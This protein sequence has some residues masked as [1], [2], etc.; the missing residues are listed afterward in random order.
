MNRKNACDLFADRYKL[1][2]FIEYDFNIK[3]LTEY[4]EKTKDFLFKYDVISRP[5]YSDPSGKTSGILTDL[6]TVNLSWANKIL[7]YVDTA[8]DYMN[9]HYGYMIENLLYNL[10]LKGQGEIKFI[11]ME[12]IINSCSS[13][14][15]NNLIVLLCD[16]IESNIIAAF[17]FNQSNEVKEYFINDQKHILGSQQWH[18]SR[19]SRENL[20]IITDNKEYIIEQDIKYNNCRFIFSKSNMMVCPYWTESDSI[21]FG[22][23]TKMEA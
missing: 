8:E 9:L 15:D 6:Y 22:L 11:E 20:K 13:D 19:L 14:N 17:I 23:T 2:N 5:F 10:F 4:I 3:S 21:F 18:W 12:R 7:P 1:G 16:T